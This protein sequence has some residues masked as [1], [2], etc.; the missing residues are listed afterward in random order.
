M[1]AGERVGTAATAKPIPSAADVQQTVWR[2]FQERRDFQPG[3]PITGDDV[4]PLLAKL[5][6][7]GLPLDDAE[8]ILEAVPDKDAFLVQQ[9]STPEGRKFMRR[10]SSYP[11]VYDRLDR[12]AS[13]PH[14][15]QTVSD[16]IRNP[17]GEKMVAYMTT[18]ASGNKLARV[19]TK[20]P[21]RKLF[22]V[23]TSRIYTVG[24]LLPRLQQSRTAA[25]EA[26]ARKKSP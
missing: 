21:E 23:P 22:T 5:Q 10:I 1:A 2:Y 12:L 7:K 8:E 3:D 16:L 9:F 26:A 15:E 6:R 24:M 13:L 11:N 17:G 20:L 14:G 19:L 4:R 18:T 25:L